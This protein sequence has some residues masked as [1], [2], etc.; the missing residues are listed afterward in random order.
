M[1]I[2]PGLIHSPFRAD[3][4]PTCSFYYS[5]SNRLY[6]HDFAT[7]EHIDV[8][9]AVKK[10]F[11]LSYSEAIKKIVADHEKFRESEELEIEKAK[12]K[13]EFTIAGDDYLNYFDRYHISKELLLKYNVYPIRTLYINEEPAGKSTKINPIFGYL[14]PSGN[15]KIYRPL[16]KDKTKKWGGNSNS[17]DI[18]GLKQLPKRGR[19]LFITSSM[20]DVIMLKVLGYNSI[21]FNGEGYGVSGNSANI[22]EEALSSLSK[23]FEHIIFYLDSD[24]AGINFS[25]KLRQKYSRKTIYNPINKPKDISDYVEKYGIFKAKRLIKKLLSKQFKSKGGFLEFVES[26][27]NS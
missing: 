26:L 17:S 11:K 7:E 20:K 15:I 14:F 13:I 10:L 1:E 23:R 24:N 4:N 16:T 25:E 27:N 22:M 9:E 3:K 6:L 21:A 12:N 5:K 2:T 19:I 8:I 18:A